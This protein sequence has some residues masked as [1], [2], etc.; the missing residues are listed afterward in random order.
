LLLVV[1]DM[2]DPDGFKCASRRSVLGIRPG[3][4]D[5]GVAAPACKTEGTGHNGGHAK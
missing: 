4:A 5:P 3:A 1:H 2:G